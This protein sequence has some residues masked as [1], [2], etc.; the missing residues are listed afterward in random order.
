MVH[1]KSVI[2]VTPTCSLRFIL[3]SYFVCICVSFDR[4]KEYSIVKTFL[5]VTFDTGSISFQPYALMSL[6]LT[7]KKIII[8]LRKEV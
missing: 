2:E 1:L 7:D 3:K 4:G 6:I 8:L 5:L